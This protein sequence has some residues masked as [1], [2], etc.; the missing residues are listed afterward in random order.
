MNLNKTMVGIMDK[1][2]RDIQK[3][4]H[5]EKLERDK[6][7]REIQKQRKVDRKEK[8]KQRTQKQERRR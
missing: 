8:E 3:Q 4:S 7:S 5:E 2:K 1:E 6:Q